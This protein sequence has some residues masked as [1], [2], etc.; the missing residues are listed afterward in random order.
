MNDEIFDLIYIRKNDSRIYHGKRIIMGHYSL[1]DPMT[2]EKLRITKHALFRDYEFQEK[3]SKESVR[4]RTCPMLA[5][6]YA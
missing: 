6:K 1:R 4:K 5:Q 3:L 2:G